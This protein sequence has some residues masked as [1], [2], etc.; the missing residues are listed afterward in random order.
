MTNEQKTQIK[1]LRQSGYGYATIAESLG[2]TKNQVS[3]FCRRNDL[4]GTKATSHIKERPN[5]GCCRNCGKPLVQVPGRKLVKFCSDSCRVNWWNSHPEMVRQ[6]AIYHFTCACCGK[7]FTA[8]G[9]ARRKYC[10][11][12]CYIADRFKGGDLS[13]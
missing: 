6:K 2:L 7:K 1:Q 13:E 3:A 5:I 12:G 9:N 10:S 4:M 8:Y 11:H